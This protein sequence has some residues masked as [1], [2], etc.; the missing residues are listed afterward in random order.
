V[1]RG[2]RSGVTGARE[3]LAPIPSNAASEISGS[4]A[5]CGCNADAGVVTVRQSK[6]GKPRHF[7][8]TD[9]RHRLFATVRARKLGNELIF[10]RREGGGWGKSHQ[11]RPILD[12]CERAK[13]KPAVSFHVDGTVSKRLCSKYVS[14]VC[15][16]WRKCNPEA[17]A[18]R[19]EA[20]ED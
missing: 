6:A 10:T 11:L 15:D 16:L 18:V 20:D 8:L 1:S 3:S 12:A 4:D 2:Q 17:P 14:G 5:R 19:R 7:V 13:I 9:E